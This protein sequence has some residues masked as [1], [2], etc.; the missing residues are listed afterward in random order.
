[1]K[2]LLISLCFIIFSTS[3]NAAVVNKV[4]IKNNNKISDETI[5]TYGQIEIG[6]NYSKEDINEVL[7]N[8]YNTNFFENISLSLENN[9]LIIDV[10][11]NK[12][13]QSVIIKG[14]DSNQIK[15]SILK[16]LYSKDKAPF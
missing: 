1:M 16:N 14:V 9:T 8:L 6:K 13:I 15:D 12:I 3:I 4:L 2:K 10:K 7:K 11:E 5:I